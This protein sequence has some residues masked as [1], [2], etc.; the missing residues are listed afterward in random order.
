MPF[1]EI[2]T[3]PLCPYCIRAKRLF[4]QKGFEVTEIDI[5]L[6][7]SRKKE[8]LERSDGRWTVP[9]IFI[10]GRGIGGSDDLVAL[11]RAGGLDPLLECGAEHCPSERPDLMIRYQLRCSRGHGFE[12]WFRGSDA[13]AD[14]VQRLACPI[15][16]DRSIEKAIMA[17]AVLQR[18]PAAEPAPTAVRRK[19]T[20]RP[21]ADGRAGA[22]AGSTS[23]PG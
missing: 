19:A 11:D 2:Y 14:E 7:S 12:G 10:D 23:G 15:C 16:D 22:G 17:P 21:S 6:S 1:I 8:M 20:T 18:G 3:K 13:F 9:Q 4:K 5:W